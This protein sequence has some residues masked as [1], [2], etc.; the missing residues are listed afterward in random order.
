MSV[1][2]REGNREKESERDK[3]KKGAR[4]KGGEKARGKSLKEQ[5]KKGQRALEGQT[6]CLTRSPRNQNP[7]DNAQS[8]LTP[9]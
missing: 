5:N 4:Q 7:T 8:G 1:K 6:S 2:H 9:R 3:D